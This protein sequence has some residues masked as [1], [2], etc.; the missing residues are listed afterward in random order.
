MQNK[1]NKK[2]AV[3]S[4]VLLFFMVAFVPAINSST[5]KS[6]I[7]YS[8]T[9]TYDVYFGTTSPPPKVASN[10]SETTYDPGTLEYNTTYY[11][12]IIAW[13]EQGES[14]EGPIWH[15]TTE[16]GLPS[17]ETLNANPV[18]KTNATLHGKILEDGGESCKVRFRYREMGQPDWIYPSDWHGSYNTDETFSEY[19]DGLNTSTL[20]EFGAGVK[21]IAG[22]EWGETRNFTTSTNQPPV[23][24]ISAVNTADKKTLVNFD[25]SGSYDPD[26]TITAYD[27]DFGDGDT[28]TGMVV[29]HSFQVSGTYTVTLQ[30]TDD[31]GATGNV[32]HQITINNNK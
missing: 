15:F 31:N 4:I 1:F 6:N 13:N 26:G 17:V 24:V 10:Q 21:N 27:W 30:V 9:I 20:Y 28:D 12:Q 19:I 23:A 7:L 5:V 2:T 22:E 25:G 8:D 3:F 11:W 18:G 14:A 16:L 29:N 32:T